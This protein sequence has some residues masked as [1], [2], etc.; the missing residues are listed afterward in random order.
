MESVKPISGPDGL[1]DYLNIESL[2]QTA[3]RFELI[4]DFGNVKL[5]VKSFVLRSIRHK[6]IM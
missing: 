6:S 4:G 5:Q 2:I 3:N 1:I